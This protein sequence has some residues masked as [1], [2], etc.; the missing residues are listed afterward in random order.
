MDKLKQLSL[1]DRF[2]FAFIISL[3]T[4]EEHSF[5]LER[6]ILDLFEEEERQREKQKKSN[7]DI[8]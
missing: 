1:E 3:Y 4:L 8:N 5:K 7:I 2:N 6:F